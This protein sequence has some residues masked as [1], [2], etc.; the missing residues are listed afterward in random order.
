MLTA[1]NQE[2]LEIMEFSLNLRMED[3]ER[4]GALPGELYWY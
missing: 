2:L 4:I 1:D 3:F